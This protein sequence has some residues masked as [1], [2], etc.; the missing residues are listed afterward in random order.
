MMYVNKEAIA[1]FVSLHFEKGMSL[2]R[3]Y[4]ADKVGFLTNLLSCAFQGWLITDQ[5]S[6]TALDLE[7]W[8]LFH[9]HLE[10]L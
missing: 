7:M 5:K 6:Q 3:F 1:L 8:N 4:F 2:I 9:H 10:V